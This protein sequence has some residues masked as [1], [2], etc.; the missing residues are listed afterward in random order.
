[1]RRVNM[2]W[3]HLR[4]VDLRGNL[5]RLRKSSFHEIRKTLWLCDAAACLLYAKAMFLALLLLRGLV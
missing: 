3:I 5:W 1:M 4:K 2:E